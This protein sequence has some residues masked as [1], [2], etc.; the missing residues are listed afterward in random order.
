M[1]DRAIQVAAAES[2]SPLATI[3][4][5][6]ETHT[7]PSG[8]FFTN[9]QNF[10]ISG[11]HFVSQTVVQQRARRDYRVLPLGDVDLRREIDIKHSRGVVERY[12]L[13]GWVRKVYAARVG[14]Q[15]MVVALYRGDQRAREEW[16]KEVNGVRW[17]RHPSLFQLYGVSSG[18]GIHAAIYHGDLRSLVDMLSG[19]RDPLARVELSMQWVVQYWGAIDE[20][21][22]ILQ[23][24]D[25]NRQL[26]FSYFLRMSTGRLCLSIEDDDG[27]ASS[28]ER[29]Q[30][31]SLR[32]PVTD[33][34][35]E[36]NGLLALHMPL[37]EV[38]TLCRSPR[39]GRG[40]AP[41]WSAHH[42]APKLDFWP[43]QVP[44][45]S[46]TLGILADY[47]SVLILSPNKSTPRAA[48][49]LCMLPPPTRTILWTSFF[50]SGTH[51]LIVE[52]DWESNIKIHAAARQPSVDFRTLPDGWAYC[53]VQGTIPQARFVV[54]R[55][56]DDIEDIWASQA[57]YVP[58]QLEL[59]DATSLSNY[60]PITEFKITVSF[61]AATVNHNVFLSLASPDRIFQHDTYIQR[62]AYWALDRYGNQPLD[63]TAAHAF[64]LPDLL[65]EAIV[66]VVHYPQT[67]YEE[68]KSVHKARGFDPQSADIALSLGYPAFRL[69]DRCDPRFPNVQIF[70][71]KWGEE[72][73]SLLPIYKPDS[74]EDIPMA[75]IVW[76]VGL[77]ISAFWV[78]WIEN[79]ITRI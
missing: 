6:I 14:G 38:H 29:P 4:V 73:P 39:P 57:E 2:S 61:Q 66:T 60:A 34:D 47:H 19:N 30:P 15:D 43:N 48:I 74:N 52:N 13:R 22:H 63:A 12:P 70:D 53:S 72:H 69:P 67:Y 26:A 42:D 31:P 41:S 71:P 46:H 25:G 18:D 49:P 7:A 78:Q 79:N 50:P 77:I 27:P 20:V 44:W 35:E 45:T 51:T 62:V 24:L 36:S 58:A 21:R 56:Y 17:A 8:S 59:D 65:I 37:E 1:D 55:R 64:G 28:G 32:H 40:E 16:E 23:S 54:S 10:E 76:F 68:I 11:G 75:F 3:P 9:A 33:D 5:N